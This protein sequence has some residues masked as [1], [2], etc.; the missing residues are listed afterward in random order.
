LRS[1]S[2]SSGRQQ[3]VKNRDELTPIIEKKFLEKPAA[4]W[5]EKLREVGVPCAPIQTIAQVA[6]DPQVLHDNMIVEIDVPGHGKMKTLGRPIKV[7]GDE[8]TFTPPPKLGEHTDDILKSLG[9]YS[10]NEIATLRE[11]E[12]I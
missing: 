11:N 7:R 1:S 5:I 12:V 3:R 10:E 6:E 2:T 8:E 4:F 9:G